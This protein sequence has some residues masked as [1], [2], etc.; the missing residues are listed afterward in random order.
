VEL[1]GISASLAVFFCSLL[2]GYFFKSLA[3][4]FIFLLFF[5]PS[6]KCLIKMADSGDADKG[7]KLFKTRCAQCHTVEQV[8]FSLFIWDTSAF[9]LT[10]PNRTQFAGWI[11]QAG[12]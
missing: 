11:Q 9:I 8:R 1:V 6:T 4:V 12:T 3:L 10:I 7:A 2:F 5:V